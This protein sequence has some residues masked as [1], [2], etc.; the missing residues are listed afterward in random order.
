MKITQPS[1]Q[2]IDDCYQILQSLS[3]ERS[4]AKD[5][6]FMHAHQPREDWKRH[7]DSGL[8]YVATDDEEVLGFVIAVELGGPDTE[9]LEGARGKT[10]WTEEGVLQ[11]PELYFIEKVAVSENAMGRGIGR[12][13]YDYM[14]S[15]H[16]KTTFFTAL[17]EKPLA[18]KAS[19]A[20]HTKMG[21][22]RV[23]TFEDDAFGALDK[24]QSGVF[25]RPA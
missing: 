10:T 19:E 3:S 15:T 25:L 20:F 18:N 1:T 9:H 5:A 22:H 4:T 7:E 12:K 24:Y 23:A 17:V 16:P 8:F 2:Q 6:G 21:F 13:L 11:I 14:F